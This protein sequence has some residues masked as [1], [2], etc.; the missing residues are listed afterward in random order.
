MLI[1]FKD[2]GKWGYYNSQTQKTIPAQFQEDSDFVNGFAIVKQYSNLC[3][4]VI[5]EDGHEIIPF[6]FSRIKKK[7]NGLF[8]AGPEFA[9]GLIDNMGQELMA[10][11][12]TQIQFKKPIKNDIINSDTYEEPY[13]WKSDYRDA[14]EDDPEAVWGR[15]W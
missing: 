4:G 5:D 12:Y 15:K 1:N 6:I 3:Y 14:F 9:Y 2:K 8:K 7:K 13:D 10:C 11:D